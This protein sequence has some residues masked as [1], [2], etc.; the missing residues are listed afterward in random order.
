L[1]V[2]REEFL[3]DP[4]HALAFAGDLADAVLHASRLEQ[5]T[6][7]LR[8]IHELMTMVDAEAVSER[9]TTT[10]LDLVELEHGTLFLH[11]PRYERY[12]VSYSNDPGYRE[13]NEFLPGVPADVLQ[14]AL[15]SPS[16]SLSRAAS[17]SCR[18]RSTTIFSASSAFP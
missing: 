11:D 1:H 13:T 6:S 18:C 5:E 17:S 4:S 16:M 15:A 9:I 3:R 10:V 7:Y 8:E 2:T 14:K 12:V